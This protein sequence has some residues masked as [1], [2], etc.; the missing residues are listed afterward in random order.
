[1]IDRGEPALAH[2]A[3][4]P[5]EFPALVFGAGKLANR[6]IVRNVLYPLPATPRWPTDCRY[7]FRLDDF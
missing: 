1:M 4:L 5:A 7:A 6:K 2:F 3:R